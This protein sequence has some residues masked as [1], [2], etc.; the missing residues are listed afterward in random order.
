MVVP[1]MNSLPSGPS[2]HTRWIGASCWTRTRGCRSEH[3]CCCF[4]S[5]LVVQSPGLAAWRACLPRMGQCQAARP[6][7]LSP[8]P[9]PCC[10]RLVVPRPS[11]SACLP[12][13]ASGRAAVLASLRL[14]W[15]PGAYSQLLSFRQ[16]LQRFRLAQSRLCSSSWACLCLARPAKSLGGPPRKPCRLSCAQCSHP[17]HTAWP[18]VFTPASACRSCSSSPQGPSWRISQ[19]I[20]SNW[21]RM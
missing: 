21:R 1:Q 12:P 6:C 19:G 7:M 16:S 5:P 10:P 18:M 8:G 17:S 20:A 9:P 2:N 11:S 4:C 14:S 3:S 15:L 13:Q